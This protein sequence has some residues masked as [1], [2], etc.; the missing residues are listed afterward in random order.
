MR[1]KALWAVVL[2]ICAVGRVDCQTDFRDLKLKVGQVV[3]VTNSSGVE[4][5]GPLTVLSPLALSIDGHEFKPLP[6]LKIQ[7][8]GD[9]IW[10]GAVYGVTV[11]LVAGM[12]SAS[13]ECG[14]DW[15]TGRCTASGGMWGAAIGALF[16]WAH[17]GRTTVFL[18]TGNKTARSIHVL[19]SFTHASS[20]LVVRLSF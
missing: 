10:D 9:P 14:V 11:G 13:G 15:S 6:G 16:D 8:R 12:L 18:G 2:C 1:R 7:R 17:V 20:A 4:V 19:P 3:Y 5:G